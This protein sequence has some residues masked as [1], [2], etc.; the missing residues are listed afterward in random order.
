M[1]RPKPR[2]IEFEYTAEVSPS[3]ACGVKPVP[4]CSGQLSPTRSGMRFTTLKHDS[5]GRSVRGSI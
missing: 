1:S 3:A 4:V 2:S 5:V